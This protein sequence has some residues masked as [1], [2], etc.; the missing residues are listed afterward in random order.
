MGSLKSEMLINSGTN[1]IILK[2]ISDVCLIIVIFKELV[3]TGKFVFT[4]VSASIILY[5]IHP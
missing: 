4:E 5:E 3:R 2:D 1:Q